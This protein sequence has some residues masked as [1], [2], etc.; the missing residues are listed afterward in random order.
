VG[1]RAYRALL[2]GN[3]RFPRDPALL[4]DLHGP[5]NDVRVLRRALTD[6]Q[7]GLFQADHVHTLTNRPKRQVV[8]AVESFFGDAERDDVLFFYYSGHGQKDRF[9]ELFLCAQDTQTKSLWATAIKATDLGGIMRGSPSRA[10]IVVLDCC[11]SGAAFKGK[12]DLPEKLSGEGRF[13]LT[14]ARA[15]DLASDAVTPQSASPFTAALADALGSGVPQLDSDGDGYITVGDLYTYVRD[16]VRG[17]A[18]GIPQRQFDKAVDE[19]AVAR[20][21]PLRQADGPA[22]RGRS[23]DLSSF[24]GLTRASSEQQVVVIAM[25]ISLAYQGVRVALDRSDFSDKLRRRA[26]YV[27]GETVGYTHSELRLVLTRDGV[28]S[29][30]PGRTY[31]ASITRIRSAAHLIR[32]LHDGRPVVGGALVSQSWFDKP[33][34]E[35]GVVRR[36]KGDRMLGGKTIV[37]LAY[38]SDTRLLRFLSPWPEWGDDGYG[39]LSPELLQLTEFYAVEAAQVTTVE[40]AGS[41][42]P[43]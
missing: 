23:V 12:A 39:S 30:P 27:D 37:I 20:A 15:A 8:E 19:V 36:V 7:A 16:R 6:A 11:H 32:Q 22:I 1:G 31:R 21:L 43:T 34:A 41:K 10:I 13:I 3:G 14:S 2:V 9:G 18:A 17:T 28:A 40:D 38:N 35:N 24:A 29:D 42:Q 26:N 33:T 5:R 25:E 4:P